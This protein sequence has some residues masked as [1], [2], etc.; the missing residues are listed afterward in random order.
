MTTMTSRAEQ[1]RIEEEA[2][3]WAA[4][5]RGRGMS[6]Q[7]HAA[8]AAWLEADPDHRWVLGRYRELSGQLDVQLGPVLESSVVMRSA[9]RRWRWRVTGAA[10]AAASIAL[11]VVVWNS[12]SPDF[13]TKTAERHGATL[14]DGSRVEL[15]AQTS[16]TV[17]FRPGERRVRL[18]RGEALFSV[19]QDFQRPF[20]VET[21]AGAVRVT[22]TVF[23]VR[24]SRDERVEVTVLEGSVRLRATSPAL[25]DERV[26]PGQQATMT[27]SR[28][29]LRML[30]AEAAQDVAAWR[31]GQAIFNDTPLAEVAE[32]FAAYRT[33]A[34]TVD[35]A[36]ADWQIGG[37]YSL[38]D[39]DGLLRTLERLLPVRVH[40]GADGTV[41]I[42][43]DGTRP[44]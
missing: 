11:A 17:D 15:N 18:A 3:L 20:V 43:A 34:I 40:R 44:K 8:L 28:I 36:V 32:R 2:S 41:R 25:A 26:T 27:A 12:R 14:A 35:P 31:L 5:L 39:L 13:S 1:N 30:S 23:N 6:E 38:D 42:V 16:L 4:R 9:A 33:H 7:D 19:A 22:G 10:M 37:R 21:T 24:A 29:A